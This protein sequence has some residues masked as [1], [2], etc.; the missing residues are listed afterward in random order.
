[1]EGCVEEER[2]GEPFGA[3]VAHC[4]FDGLGRK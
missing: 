2:P 4:G 1:M 3:G